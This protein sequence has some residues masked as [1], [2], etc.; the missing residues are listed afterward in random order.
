MKPV[1]KKDLTEVIRTAEREIYKK[2]GRRICLKPFENKV[3]TRISEAVRLKEVETE[4]K[5]EQL[6][7]SYCTALQINK[8]CLLTKCKKTTTCMLRYVY[9]HLVYNNLPNIKLRQIAHQ[10]LLRDHTA[11]IYMQRTADSLF[12]TKYPPFMDIFQKAKHLYEPLQEI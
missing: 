12:F 7:N 4:I 6:L 5:L 10:L 2:T 9:C 11:V 3:Q 1:S 8:D